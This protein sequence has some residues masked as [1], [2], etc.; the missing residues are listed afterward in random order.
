MLELHIE[1]KLRRLKQR[2][3]DSILQT[4]DSWAKVLAGESIR[5]RGEALV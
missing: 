5:Y 4:I 2:G 1:T 3:L